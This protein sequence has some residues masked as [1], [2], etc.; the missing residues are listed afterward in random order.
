M[1]LHRRLFLIVVTLGCASLAACQT[2]APRGYGLTPHVAHDAPRLGASNQIGPS[3]IFQDRSGRVLYP[4]SDQR[5]FYSEHA[6]TQ[7][8][9][10]YRHQPVT[11]RD[12]YRQDDRYQRDQRRYRD[13]R[14]QTR[15]YDR[16]DRAERNQRRRAGTRVERRDGRRNEQTTRQISRDQART[17]RT[18]ENGRRQTRARDS[19]QRR[20]REQRGQQNQ[21]QLDRE[22]QRATQQRRQPAQQQRQQTRQ[23]ETRDARQRQE[24]INQDRQPQN[25]TFAEKK[26]RYREAVEA[27]RREARRTGQQA[28]RL[29]R[30]VDYGLSEGK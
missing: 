13:D 3:R 25:L 21:V 22:R 7:Y 27:T 28:D 15:E 19:E 11:R 2:I 12:R 8:L 14:R 5:I 10:G 17:R 20:S 26:Q 1:A 9:D 18:D 16:D 6:R 24:R 29:P 30:A 4:T 23:V